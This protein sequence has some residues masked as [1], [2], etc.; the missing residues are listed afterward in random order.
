MI[1]LA[2]S[3]L[4]ACLLLSFFCIGPQT[5]LAQTQ[6]TDA[7]KLFTKPLL[8]DPTSSCLGDCTFTL[9]GG[10][11]LHTSLKSVFG[12][13]TYIPPGRWNWRNS[14]LIA[15]AFSRKLIERPGIWEIDGEMGIGQRFGQ[16]TAT[17]GW[18]AIYLRWNLFPWNEWVKTSAAISTG[19][20]YAL[21]KDPVEI[22]RND[23]G[24]RGANL[25]HYLSPEFTFSLPTHPD[26]DLILR[27]HHRSG[28]RD[29][30]LGSDL[31][32]VFF[33]NSSGGAQYISTGLRHHF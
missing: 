13:T 17:E 21:K 3:R 16:L 28:G 25:L 10:H 29:A 1:L 19:I 26:W 9:Y 15:G 30:V 12:W 6:K 2:R 20:N 27:I 18:A 5:I 14:N 24:G 7:S 22:E 4:F 32:R 33:T 11:Y 23:N 31:S 8:F